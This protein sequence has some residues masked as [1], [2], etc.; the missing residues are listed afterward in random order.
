MPAI[1][2]AR[3]KK[4]S[5]QLADSF[6]Q[7][8]EFVHALRDTLEYY[9][10]RSLRE[11]DST[12]PASVLDTYRTPPV[13]LRHIEIE[14]AP[15]ALA[16][17]EQALDLADRL[18]DEGWL[19]TRL[20]AASL[21][22]RLPPREERLLARLTAW[23]TQVRDPSVR[24]ALLSTSLV[25]LRKET[26]DQFL[27][28]VGEWLNPERARMWSNGIQAL[29][30]LIKDPNFNNLPPV[31]DTLMHVVE[32]APGILQKDLID[33][34]QALY[35]ISPTETTYFLREVISN[36]STSMTAT[37]FRR[38]SPSLPPK[39]AESI[40]DLVKIKRTTQ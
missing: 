39:L 29:L 30:P 8:D 35:S 28:L 17:P 4:Q 36:S 26:P 23:T 5:V 9:V 13:I 14:I 11:V 15:L 12:A 2:L 7:P 24:S 6:D 37:T 22:G 20:L 1:E 18:W 38:I 32:A 33:L 25:R 34:F 19:E 21:L 16:N 40:R 27:L 10:N 31:F 3:L